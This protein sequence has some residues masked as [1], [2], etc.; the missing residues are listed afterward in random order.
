MLHWR[1]MV[2]DPLPV[3]T[4]DMRSLI[5][6]LY[7]ILKMQ[8]ADRF[9]VFVNGWSQSVTAEIFNNKPGSFP[10]V[11]FFREPKMISVTY[12]G[13][14]GFSKGENGIF[15]WH[16]H[17]RVYVKHEHCFL[18]PKE[19]IS[20]HGQIKLPYVINGYLNT[21]KNDAEKCAYM[22]MCLLDLGKE[23]PE[24]CIERVTDDGDIIFLNYEPK[25]VSLESALELL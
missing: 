7:Y 12:C 10:V 5:L 2:I 1:S 4:Y 14:R 17:E 9:V 6:G 16:I 8:V 13:T 21:M 11:S 18:L 22:I 24:D 3:L 19:I 25:I 20:I 23:I 15:F